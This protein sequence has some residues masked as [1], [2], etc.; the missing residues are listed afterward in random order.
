MTTPPDV[1]PRPAQTPSTILLWLDEQVWGHRMHDEQSPWLVYLEFLNVFN[2]ETTK[3]RAFREPEGFNRLSYQPAKRLYLRNTLFNNPALQEIKLRHSTDEARWANWSKQMETGTKGI[4][5]PDF[6]YLRKRFH[7][8]ED[9]CEVVEFIRSTSLEMASNKRWTSKFVFPYGASCL[10]ED[11]DNEASTNDRRFFG[12]TGELLYL[13]FCRTKR[14]D[15]LVDLIGTKCLKSDSRWNR[16]V[17][18]L[19]PEGDVAWDDRAGS[20]LPYESHPC[21]DELADD[22]ITILRLELPDYDPIPHLV[23][24]TGLHLAKYQLTVARQT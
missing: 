11:L 10:Y 22:W 23:N 16:L 12:R 17:K 6:A 2:H 20:Y 1:I 3:G 14:K 5:H 4:D 8:F 7:S 24:L 18:A 13:M 21:F 19:Q 15:V 9:F